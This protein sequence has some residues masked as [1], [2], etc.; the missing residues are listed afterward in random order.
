MD[1]LAPSHAKL[2]VFSW[3][4]YGQSVATYTVTTY[5]SFNINI[6]SLHIPVLSFTE[7]SCCSRPI[8][9]KSSELD[10]SVRERSS[11][12]GRWACRRSRAKAPSRAG[13]FSGSSFQMCPVSRSFR[14][15]EGDWGGGLG[16]WAAGVEDGAEPAGGRGFSSKSTG[17]C[18][19]FFF[20]FYV[21]LKEMHCSVPWLFAFDP[22]S[23]RFT[24][25]LVNG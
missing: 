13:R 12:W 4:T 23:L 6:K 7:K 22:C 10:P 9:R 24:L 16:G 20:I 25:H 18:F 8:C 1:D 3:Q 17:F 5:T 2:I 14:G 15:G 11:R 21:S 19:R